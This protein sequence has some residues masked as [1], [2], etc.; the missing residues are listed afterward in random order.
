MTDYGHEIRLGIFPTPDA[1]D[2]QRAVTLAVA[3]DTSGIDLV[4][5]QDHPYAKDQ[6]D[7]WTLLSWIAARTTSVRVAQNVANLPLRAPVVLANS[8]AT[9]DLLSGGRAELGLG[10]GG[11][12]DAIVAAGGPRRSPGEAVDALIEAIDV[13]RQVWRGEGSVRVEGEHYRV[14]GLHSGPAPGGRPAIW[15]GAYG[16]RMQRVTGRLGDGWLPSM[17]YLAPDKLPEANARIDEAAAAAGRAPQDVIR[18]YNVHG[19]FGGSTAGAGGQAGLRGS[20]TDWAEQLAELALGQGM[21]TFILA[22][23]DVRTVQVFGQEVGPALRDLVQAERSGRAGGD[24]AAANDQAPE[25]VEVTTAPG[26]P[27]NPGAGVTRAQLPQGIIPTPDDGTRLTGELDWDEPSRPSVGAPAGAPTAYTPAQL[28]APQHLIDI[29]DHLREELSR[30]REVVDQVREGHLQ[31]GQA[32]SIINTMTMRQNTWTLGAFCQSY[33]RIVTG[34]HTLEDRSVFPHLR[35]AEP[36]VATVLDRLEEEH[37]VIA[38]VLDRLDRAL[39]AL[40]DEEGYGGQGRQALD[41]LSHS[42][43]L[44]TDTLLSHLSYEERELSGPLARHGFS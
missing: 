28:A 41:E 23:D 38:D 18:L 29:H 6:L 27:G 40:V 34:H 16:P 32:R 14:K 17:G 26:A 31:V 44:L 5:V 3:A 36:G 30:V 35:R 37:E 4:S 12:W 22:T 25:S 20:A 15:I 8:V 43:D 19:R 10:T 2:P 7:S 42:V 1:A 11:F 24:L 39:V 33:C 13:V 21:S 9:L